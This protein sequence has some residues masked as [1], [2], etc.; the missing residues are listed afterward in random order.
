MLH[1]DFDFRC[2]ITLQYSRGPILSEVL[3]LD[4]P[5]KVQIGVNVWLKVSTFE[6]ELGLT[7]NS[8]H[9]G[10]SLEKLR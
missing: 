8:V 2:N 6:H 4:K 10:L 3:S 9:F 7:K 1:C 5:D